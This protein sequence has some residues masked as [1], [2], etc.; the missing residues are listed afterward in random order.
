MHLH[1]R[2]VLFA[3]S[4]ALLLAAGCD[5]PETAT[6]ESA[7][8]QADAPAGPRLDVNGARI[9]AADAEPGNWLSHGRSYDE[10]RFSPLQQINAG[11]AEDLGLDWYYQF[12]TK[13][14]L[15]ATPIVVD[16]MMFTSGAW[17]RVYALDAKSGELLW[18][19]DPEV[20]PEW[21]VHACC[22][23]VNRGVAL[24]QGSV[25]VGT[26]DGRLVSL[27][28]KT[29][30]VNWTVQTT[31]RSKPYT[32]TG[33]PRVVKGKV[34]IGNGGAEYGVRGY[35]SAYDAETGAMAWRFYTVPGNPAEPF[36]SEAMERAAETW[37]GEWW[38]YGGGGTVWD[39]MAFDPEL[40][41]LYIGVGNGS[42]WNQ[43]IRSPDGGDNLFL[44][45]IVALN[46]DKG[47]Y[48]WHYQTT[49]AETWDYTAT[50]HMILAD[51]E[52][53][54]SMRKV[55][56]QAPKNGFFYVLDRE[57]GELIS[58]EPY[59]QTTWATH[60]DPET[61]RPVE[62]ANARYTEGPA[63]VL[64]A[65][66][67]GH[68]WHPMAFSPLTG[69][70]YI[71]AQDIPFAYGTDENFTFTPGLWNVGVNPLFASLA[72]Q[73]PEAQAELMGMVKGQIIA[74]DPV[75][76]K[77]VWRFQ[78]ALPWNGGML[79]TA[80]NLVFQGN[81]VGDFAAYRADT[82]ERLWSTSAQT[83][84][85]ASPVTYEVDGEQYVSV[86][87]G[88]GGSLALS[89][90]EIAAA[91]NQTNISRILTYK[92]G[93]TGTLPEF[94]PVTL[95]LDPPP[96]IEDP[97]VI[98]L[99]KQRYSDRCMVCHGDGVVG[100]G[101]LPDLRYLD[102]EKHQMWLGIV[103]GGLHRDQGMVSFAEVLTAEEAQ[104]IQAFVIDRANDLADAR[105]AQ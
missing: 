7:P 69:L 72:E 54:G 68:N 92:L 9:A 8:A 18:E 60:V 52:I 41:L 31:V 44:S 80:G 22:D 20:P 75:Q 53:E 94:T 86:L 42:P 46:P 96:R 57:T 47:E 95:T 37:T 98:A 97:A 100:G 15:E 26:L 74:W 33:A 90:G 103:L 16:G 38:N 73:P 62:T 70:I 58:A 1:P 17:S 104:A 14:G 29:G 63:L 85:V 78:H 35:V 34:I 30:T 93:S 28:A 21:A 67:G 87:A 11:N 56:L 105:A 89:G 49:P 55:I 5:R 25:F 71:P 19:Y 48:V 45:S 27:N 99:G 10:Q 23:V 65:P 79:A 102:A 101:V 59:V 50:Q 43:Q 3:C 2:Y 91:T 4:T 83:G 6:V 51:L 64:P 81:S 13:R 66:Y 12:D 40:N 36:E 82:G 32:I 84:I 61:G 39:S 76:R 24:W 77:E 88:W